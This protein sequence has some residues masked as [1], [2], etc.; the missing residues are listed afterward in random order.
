MD[1]IKIRMETNTAEMM[2]YYLGKAAW[3]YDWE[4]QMAMQVTRKG[5]NWE[6][7]YDLALGG[8][9][10]GRIGRGGAIPSL[11]PRRAVEDNADENAAIHHYA[12]NL[13]I[14]LFVVPRAR[15]QRSLGVLVAG[16]LW[17]E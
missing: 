5:R 8:T 14:E 11:G 2:Q 10:D 9:N 3:Q 7:R 4:M 15:C 6:M 12:I 1:I 17:M 13:V 16:R